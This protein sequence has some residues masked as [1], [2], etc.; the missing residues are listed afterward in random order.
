MSEFVWIEFNLRKID[1]HALSA[2]E[3]ESAWRD[4]RD[5]KRGQHPEHGPYT[6][7][8]GECPSGRRITIV[9]RWNDG[10]DQKQ[11]FV[12]TAY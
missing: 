8:R 6:V 3:V 12:V 9:W 2:E 4:R 1:A 7:S 11:V 5:L 10:V